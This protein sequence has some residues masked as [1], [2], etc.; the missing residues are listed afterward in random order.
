MRRISGLAVC[1]QNGWD[2]RRVPLLDRC[3][4][5]ML[6]AGRGEPGKPASNPTSEKYRPTQG[7]PCSK[8]RANNHPR[9]PSRPR[10]SHTEP[11][12]A[13]RKLHSYFLVNGCRR[14]LS[15]EHKLLER[16]PKAMIEGRDRQAWS[17]ARQST[18]PCYPIEVLGERRILPPRARRPISN[19]H[20]ALVLGRV[21]YRNADA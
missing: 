18:S 17:V 19:L 16:P 3:R 8:S 21:R 13:G 7:R 9:V 12:S 1:Y 20:R 10:S 11:Q 4:V 2:G 15:F 6:D 5:E 14:Q